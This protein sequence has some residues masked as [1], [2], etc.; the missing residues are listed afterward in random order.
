MVSR[1]NVDEDARSGSGPVSCVAGCGAMRDPARLIGSTAASQQNHSCQPM[2]CCK[3]SASQ[4]AAADCTGLTGTSVM[5]GSV[6][7]GPVSCVAGCGVMRL[8]VGL[9]GSTAAA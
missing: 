1:A 7:R 9:T 4:L 3:H 5:Q 6:C 8:R 2:A